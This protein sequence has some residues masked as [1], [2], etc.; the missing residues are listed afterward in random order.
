MSNF[1][2]ITFRGYA[3]EVYIT[4]T[5]WFIGHGVYEIL[6]S[7]EYAKWIGRKSD[8]YLL[9]E[10]GNILVDPNSVGQYTGLFDSR[11]KGICE[12]DI[13]DSIALKQPDRHINRRIVKYIDGAFYGV[14][15]KDDSKKL[16]S[17]INGESRVIG[18]EFD[19]KGMVE[20]TYYDKY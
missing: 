15:L 13:L 9:T 14:L 5:Q 17:E 8:V 19:N 7:D 2:G 3:K 10:N 20:G 11:G 4:N 6:F 16:L 12:N 1:R 18:N